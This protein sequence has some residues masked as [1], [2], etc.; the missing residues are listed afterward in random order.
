MIK[1]GVAMRLSALCYYEAGWSQRQVMSEKWSFS[2]EFM[3]FSYLAWTLN[4]VNTAAMKQ[5]PRWKQ[6]QQCNSL[7]EPVK[8]N[9]NGIIVAAFV[10]PCV[11]YEL[12]TFQ[13]STAIFDFNL[14]PPIILPYLQTYNNNYGEV[15]IQPNAILQFQENIFRTNFIYKHLIS[16]H[17]L[18]C[19]IK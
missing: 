15:K 3:S 13:S 7:P 6:P 10:P 8:G 9:A 4:S 12:R 2:G 5:R 16:L 17:L 18:I 14:I 11:K 19:S 1:I